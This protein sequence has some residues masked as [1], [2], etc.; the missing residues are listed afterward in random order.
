MSRLSKFLEESVVQD[1]LAIE[2]PDVGGQYTDERV[3]AHLKKIN[4]AIKELRGS[5]KYDD[6][7]K[8]AMMADLNDKLDKWENV[9]RE[10]KPAPP[11]GPSADLNGEKEE[12]PPTEETPEGE[13]GAD[14]KVA[15]DRDK[16]EKEADKEQEEDD[17]DDIEDDKEEDEKRKNRNKNQRMVQK[18]ATKKKA[19]QAEGRLIKSRI[20]RVL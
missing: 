11:V 18:H 14:D 1:A 15:A 12:A 10:T 13:E 3:E 2:E 19:N 20:R 7:A 9:E 4:S 16:R 6:E 8:E 17:K 5:G